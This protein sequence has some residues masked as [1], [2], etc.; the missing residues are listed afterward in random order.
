[1]RILVFAFLIGVCCLAG[2]IILAAEDGNVKNTEYALVLPSFEAVPIKDADKAAND[3]M[4]AYNKAVK[5]LLTQLRESK[6]NTGK[7]YSIYLLGGLRAKEAVGDLVKIIDFKTEHV[8]P[9]DAI[10][11][12]GPYPAQ[13]ALSKIGSPSVEP[14]VKALGKE[15]NETR[16]KLMLM[17]LID[18]LDKDVAQFVLQKA[19]KA[20]TETEKPQYEKATAMLAG[21]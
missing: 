3:T 13:E 4:E 7:T 20:A 11:R 21:M 18:V 10:G 12:W 14:M 19:S 8:D 6:T 15:D 1:M 16:R 17:V 2:G 9:K 5:N